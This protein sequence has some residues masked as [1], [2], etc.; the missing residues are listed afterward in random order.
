M[1]L[2]PHRAFKE[3]PGG[4]TLDI[5]KE[6]T[7]YKDHL[8]PFKSVMQSEVSHC[9][10]TAFR[11]PFRTAYQAARSKIS[12][13]ATH[14]AEFRDILH[15]FVSNELESVILFL[16]HITSIEVRRINPEGG[17]S[18][19]GK[20]EIDRLDLTSHSS[21]V[22]RNVTLWMEDGTSTT[23]TWFFHNHRIDKDR[24]ASLM[25]SQLGYDIEDRLALEKLTPGV[26]IAFPLEGPSIKGSLFTL[27]PL[28][29][30][31]PGS[32]FHIN[33]T[34]ALTPDRQNLKK[35]QEVGDV[36]SREK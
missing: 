14:V 34:F 7:A 20:V 35:K 24:A 17:E 30:N 29:I 8:A 32:L 28:P 3:H 21:G 26:D 2:D 5:M 23:R 33:A 25:S 16:K 6:G 27:L 1:I 10:G 9:S 36:R 31:I 18:V 11:L 15:S 22:H 13:K 12:D 4:V 19:L